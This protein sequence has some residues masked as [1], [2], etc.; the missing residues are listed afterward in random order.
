MRICSMFG[1]W[2]VMMQ[3]KK[4]PVVI[5]RVDFPALDNLVVYLKERE[6]GKID[7]LTAEVQEL[8]G[9]L[10]QSSTTLEGAVEET[11]P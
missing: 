10:Q 3:Q 6:Q 2:V 9:R 11:R 4:D 1:R 5:V 7:A 8:T